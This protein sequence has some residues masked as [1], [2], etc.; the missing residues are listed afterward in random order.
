MMVRWS[1]K[2]QGNTR[3]TSGEVQGNFKC[4]ISESRFGK[5]QGKVRWWSGERQV[6]VRWISGE[7]QVNLRW[8]SGESQCELDFGGRETCLILS[9]CKQEPAHL[10]TFYCQPLSRFLSPEINWIWRSS[11]VPDQFYCFPAHCVG[12]VKVSTMLNFMSAFK[13]SL[14]FKLCFSNIKTSLPYLLLKRIDFTISDWLIF[15]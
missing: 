10:F 8:I 4:K 1:G 12:V 7:S 2:C 5:G 14:N 6:N 9:Q 3:W 13:I 15:S 11:I